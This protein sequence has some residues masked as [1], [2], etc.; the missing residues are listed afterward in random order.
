MWHTHI[1]VLV[2]INLFLCVVAYQV[3]VSVQLISSDVAFD[4]YLFEHEGSADTDVILP[5]WIYIKNGEDKYL[6]SRSDSPNDYVRL[7]F[8]SSLPSPESVFKVAKA[9]NAR[10]IFTDNIGRHFTR[11]SLEVDKGEE[12]WYSS[13]GPHDSESTCAFNVIVATDNKVYLKDNYS[14]ALFLCTSTTFVVPAA[15]SYL[16]EA[17]LMQIMQAAVKN[18]IVNVEYDTPAGKVHD[19]APTIALSTS[20]RNDSDGE[21]NQTLSYAY[22]KWSVGTWNNSA[23]V[24]IGIKSSFS[25]G[26]P[27]VT[28]AKFEISISG[29]YSHEWGGE[30]GTKQTVTSSTTVTVP[31]KKKAQA[32]ITILNAQIDVNFAYVQRIL[33]SNGVSV[34]EKKT[35]VYNNVD[36]WHVDVVLDNWEDV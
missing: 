27:F 3:A 25:A 29:S 13:G 16:N 10:Y 31:P 32:T 36:S 6:S 23:G 20:V 35:G 30:N 14:P 19:V 11:Y 1:L 15:S 28:N 17:S 33:W 7:A 12:W 24:E 2:L 4:I 21:V 9:G 8:R 26:V 34:E 18:E 5:E 22:E